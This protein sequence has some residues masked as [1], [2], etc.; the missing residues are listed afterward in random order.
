MSHLSLFSPRDGITL[1]QLQ[2]F[3]R[4]QT[5]ERLLPTTDQATMSV[6]LLHALS[7]LMRDIVLFRYDGSRREIYILSADDIQI[8]IA[9][10]GKWRFV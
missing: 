5:L 6:L 8:V 2:A 1:A 9:A 3:L 10:N 4:P 7:A